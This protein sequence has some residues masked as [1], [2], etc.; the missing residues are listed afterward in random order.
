[1]MYADF[2]AALLKSMQERY[3]REGARVLREGNMNTYV[4]LVSRTGGYMDGAQLLVG[5]GGIKTMLFSVTVSVALLVPVSVSVL[6]VVS[7]SVSVVV[8]MS[9]SVVSASVVP[10]VSVSVGCQYRCRC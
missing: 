4:Q 3:S 7:A 9:V 10:S 1:M 2:E 5:E 8:V 6:V